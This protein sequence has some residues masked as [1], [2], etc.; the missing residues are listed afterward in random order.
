MNRQLTTYKLLQAV[1]TNPATVIISL[2]NSFQQQIDGDCL[3]LGGRLDR[4][5][6]RE[7]R[8]VFGWR[9]C[10]A[11]CWMNIVRTIFLR[12]EGSFGICGCLNFASVSSSWYSTFWRGQFSVR[13]YNKGQSNE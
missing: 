2:S 11:S 4:E 3:I 13:I 5:D 7:G 12:H 8:M 10:D 9:Q 6:I 1:Q